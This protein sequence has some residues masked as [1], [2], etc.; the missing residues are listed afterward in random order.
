MLREYWILKRIAL[1]RNRA[2]EFENRGEYPS[3]H[4]EILKLCV[5]AGHLT[6]K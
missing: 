4:A 6:R 5:G 1:V 2:Q 3:C